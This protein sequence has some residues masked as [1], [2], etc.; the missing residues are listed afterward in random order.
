M[1]LGLV[2]FLVLVGLCAIAQ[3]SFFSQHSYAVP[4]TAPAMIAIDTYASAT[5]LY[6]NQKL[7]GPD[8]L[9]STLLFAKYPIINHRNNRLSL[10]VNFIE[11][12]I[13]GPGKLTE[14]LFSS[15]LAYSFNY[16]KHKGISFAMDF[17]L[18]FKK[19]NLNDIQTGEMWTIEDGFDP[20]LS[21][22]EYL[23]AENLF[24]PKLNASIF[25]FVNDRN[26]DTKS[27]LGFSVFQL[28]KTKDSFYNPE[29][30]I[31]NKQFTSLGGF[32]IYDNNQVA[33]TPKFIITSTIARSYVKLG[34]DFNY[35]LSQ[36][37]NNVSRKGN[38]INVEVNYQLNKG[39]QFGFQYLQPRYI[40]GMAY[41]ID[42]SKKPE[43]S[44][45]S[46]AVEVLLVV[47]N[48]VKLSPQKSRYQRNNKRRIKKKKNGKKQKTTKKTVI[49]PLDKKEETDIL[50]IPITNL[51]DTTRKDDTS[52]TIVDD[53]LEDNTSLVSWESSLELENENRLQFEYNSIQINETSLQKLKTLAMLL[54]NYENT[55]IILIGHTDNIGSFKSNNAFSIKR[56]NAAAKVLIELGIPPSKIIVQGRGELEPIDT[57]DTERG[58]SNNRR[59]GFYIIND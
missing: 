16:D 19:I 44:V 52:P 36:Y 30:L 8:R 29:K 3:Q 49:T 42:V 17:G 11:N 7:V 6:K 2:V 25:W 48:P 12:K 50:H 31:K 18:V 22:G 51:V 56:A 43:S 57:N 35:S 32:R 20:G 13:K 24:Y 53:S 54:K 23:E 28:N 9:I 38:S 45:F 10:G 14:Q 58:R 21:S 55:K 4:E 37:K 5:L 39:A 59:I 27:Y 34:M 47:R 26:E 15:T 1:K 41:H 33:I 46:N 40:V